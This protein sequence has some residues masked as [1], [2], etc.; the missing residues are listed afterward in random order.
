MLDSQLDAMRWLGTNLLILAVSLAVSLERGAA[1]RAHH[2]FLL[3]SHRHGWLALST[4]IRGGASNGGRPQSSSTPG[5]DSDEEDSEVPKGQTDEW[6]EDI[7]PADMD[8]DEDLEMFLDAQEFIE[9]EEDVIEEETVDE[10]FGEEATE[11]AV[12]ESASNSDDLL[13]E[14]EDEEYD[15]ADGDD[16]TQA[17]IE[18]VVEEAVVEEVIEDS[19][20]EAASSSEYE[21]Y[22]DEEDDSEIDEGTSPETDFDKQITPQEDTPSTEDASQVEPEFSPGVV[23]TEVE[24]V[25]DEQPVIAE[26]TSVGFPDEPAMN[27]PASVEAVEAESMADTETVKE[28]ESY[29]PESRVDSIPVEV[30][31][32]QLHTTDDD[33]MAF[34]DRM[35]LAD[36]EGEASLTEM[37]DE[38]VIEAEESLVDEASVEDEAAVVD[39]AAT[40]AA[41]VADNEVIDSANETV[42]ESESSIAVLD[43][44]TKR[45]LRKDLKYHRREV[46]GMKPEIALVLAEK[47]LQRP[48]EGIPPSWYTDEAKHQRAI[49]ARRTKNV[50][51]KIVTAPVAYAVPIVLGGLA[52]YG[53]SDI[54]NMV[55]TISS[56]N[57]KQS[58]PS[59]KDEENDKDE[60]TVDSIQ[61]TVESSPP[62]PTADG[63]TIPPYDDERIPKKKD[64][65][66]WLDKVIMGIVKPI[67]AFWNIR[68]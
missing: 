67:Q 9:D 57:G 62:P 34:V 46:N 65:D 20:V 42:A 37:H 43:D 30:D 18:E 28:E 5:T 6:S 8:D 59:E 10:T 60:S 24:V 36:D 3:A 64:E 13:D 51:L 61:G 54:A 39:D 2:S 31:L 58:R 32:S 22:E 29:I 47:R 56:G 25:D 53:S 33:S 35:E 40:A 50:V 14:Y 66:T 38:E 23:E 15:V 16:T 41:V 26:S 19:V 48:I 11:G 55:S 44:E 63:G 45:I 27:E 7:T 21:E 4:T 68:I 52:I 49:G 17:F 1:A 12:V